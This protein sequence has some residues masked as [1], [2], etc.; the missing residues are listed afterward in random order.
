MA[1]YRQRSLKQGNCKNAF[2]HGI[3]PLDKIPI[4]T[5]PIGNPE[6]SQHKYWLLKCTSTSTVFVK[7]P[8]IGTLKK[9]VLTQI[10]LQQNAYVPCL[11]I[12]HIYVFF[13]THRQPI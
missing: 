3:L 5:S 12:G 9:T 4:V 1:V 11:F 7:V 6:T 8:D 13:P 2:C 10:S